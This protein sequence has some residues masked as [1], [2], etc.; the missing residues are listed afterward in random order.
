MFSIMIILAH[1]CVALG[2]R[3]KYAHLIFLFFAVINAITVLCLI[4][5]HPYYL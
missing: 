1:L 3:V 4:K 2:Q 5:Y